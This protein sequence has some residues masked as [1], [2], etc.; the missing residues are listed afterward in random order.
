MKVIPQLQ[1]FL[2]LIFISFLIFL[3]DF[4][5]LLAW[6]KVG[7][8]FIST[9]I[10]FGLLESSRTIGKQLSFLTNARFAAQEN[11]ALKLQ[12]AELLSENAT[13]RTKLAETDAQLQQQ[14][15]LDP[16]TYKL[17]AARPIGLD[18]YLKIDKGLNDGVKI[19]QA[20]I[21]KDSFIGKVVSVDGKTASVELAVD[22]DSKVAAFSLNKSGKAKGVLL[23]QFGS[24]LLLDKVLH[25]EP[26]SEGDLVYS[27]GTEGY[28]PRGLIL[29]R[30]SEV[31]ETQTQVFKTAKVKPVFDVTDLEL[32]FVITE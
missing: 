13:L 21:F 3:L 2:S 23:G 12:M 16:R 5:H 17:L 18:R 1:L 24:E 20:V 8:S 7:L 19:N 11:E 29:G 27:E 26:L 9:P 30:V 25:E 15:A 31:S 10:Q 32:V 14:Q 22:P 28:L 6:P 4:I